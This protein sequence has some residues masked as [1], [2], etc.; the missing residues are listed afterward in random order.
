MDLMNIQ[1]GEGSLQMKIEDG[2][3]KVALA[4][5]GKQADAKL[6]ISLGADEYLEMLKKAIPGK[7]DDTIIDM[8]K[9]AMK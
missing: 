7:L 2:K 9:L 8:L 4:Y 3:V 5:D 6:E 1:K